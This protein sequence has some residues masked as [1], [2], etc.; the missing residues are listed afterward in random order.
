MQ[1]KSWDRPGK[2]CGRFFN[3]VIHLTD[4]GFDLQLVPP[5]ISFKAL[6]RGGHHGYQENPQQKDYELG[7]NW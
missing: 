4:W 6:K 3:G 7:R 1:L 2:S 5:D